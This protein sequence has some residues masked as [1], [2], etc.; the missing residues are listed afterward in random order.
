M[1]CA[2]YSPRN[3][4]D[5]EC[6]KTPISINRQRLVVEQGRFLKRE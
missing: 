5:V 1:V 6:P 4:K 3:T 2:S